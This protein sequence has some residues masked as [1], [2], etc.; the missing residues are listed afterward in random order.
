MC[1]KVREAL[2]SLR[3]AGN[4]GNADKDLKGMGCDR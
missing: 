1:D 3:Q 2:V 4:A